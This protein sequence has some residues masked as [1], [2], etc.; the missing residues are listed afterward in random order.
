MHSIVDDSDCY[1]LKNVKWEKL[2]H[3]TEGFSFKVRETC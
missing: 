1:F 2:G 3:C